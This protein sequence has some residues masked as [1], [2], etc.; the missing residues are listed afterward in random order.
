MPR[1]LQDERLPATASPLHV[2]LVAIAV[3]FDV[4][5]LTLLLVFLVAAATGGESSDAF[6]SDYAPL[7]VHAIPLTL[8]TV[9]AFG[10]RR[11]LARFRLTA[12][13]VAAAHMVA[14]AIAPDAAG[15]MYLPAAMLLLAAA[16]APDEQ[17]PR[18]LGYHAALAG[19]AGFLL[20]AVLLASG[21]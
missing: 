20:A 18:G 8:L 19:V 21:S 9:L 5:I 3:A 17:G 15:R 4:A 11:R 14:V 1:A 2:V 12:C 6:V 7:L 13:V 10:A 16:L